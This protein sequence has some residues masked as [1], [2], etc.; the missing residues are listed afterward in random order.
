LI[1]A[2]QGEQDGG[3]PERRR[4]VVDVFAEQRFGLGVQPGVQERRQ[5]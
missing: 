4:L 1:L 3:I 2:A 5:Q